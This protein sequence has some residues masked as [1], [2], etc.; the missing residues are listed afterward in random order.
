MRFRLRSKRNRRRNWTDRIGQVLIGS[1]RDPLT[2]AQVMHRV[3]VPLAFMVPYLVWI[4]GQTFVTM[5]KMWQGRME[6]R[7][8]EQLRLTGRSDAAL[9][10]LMHAYNRVPNEP[11]IIRGIAWAAAPAFPLQA[12]YFLEKLV[13]K[14]A[15]TAEDQMLL[16]TVYL[17]LEQ[18][19]E[20]AA[21]FQA[22]VKHQPKNPDVW[23]SWG[24]ACHQK[25]ELSEAMKAYRHVLAYSPHDLQATVGIAQLLLR[26]GTEK[27]KTKAVQMLLQQFE[28]TTASKLPGANDL[29]D[30]L[31][32]LPITDTVQRAKVASLVR[33]IP[34][35]LPSNA[36]AGIFLSYPPEPTAEQGRQRREEV[37]N[38]L[39]QHRK[40]EM[41]DRKAVSLVLQKMGENSLILDWVSLAEAA[42]DSV[43]FAQRIEALL[44][45]GLWKEAAEMARHP[46]ADEAMAR[47]GWMHTLSVL[48]TCREP[49]TMAENMITQSLNEA[50]N[51]SHY[52]VCKALGFAALDYGLYPL[53]SR[54]FATAIRDGSE[55]VS[56]IKEYLHAARRSGETAGDVMK[57]ISTRARTERSNEDMQKQSIYFNLL[58]GIE[59]ES[60]ALDLAQMRQRDPE[61]PYLK[62]LNAFTGYRLGDHAGAVRALLPLPQHRWQQGETV[63]IST[64]L[65]AGGQLKQAAQLASKITGEGVFPEEQQMLDSWQ[66][67]AQT[68]SGL[69]SSVTVLQ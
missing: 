10:M 39:A 53:A 38:F 9:S 28:R 65:A 61:D 68:D 22:M 27:E 34:D 51:G 40:L 58:C 31:L 12:K 59:I 18:P 63:V 44:S 15:A 54:A 1:K 35:P 23:R 8:A 13:A 37:K 52:T 47:Q 48:S 32:N 43:M 64:I 30:L 57:V 50:V 29:A 25:G 2:P 6:A 60:T 45:S 21:V 69:L 20:A 7:K 62:F 36:V 66:S 3:L 56:P 55:S 46:A 14:E 42:G 41:D 17:A 19:V 67:R 11:E 33:Q 24:I 4:H 5:G 49:K 16:T 26:S